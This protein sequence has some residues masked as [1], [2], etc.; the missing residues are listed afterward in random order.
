MASVNM[1][2]PPV[3][4][5]GIFQADVRIEGFLPVFDVHLGLV[6]L[7]PETETLLFG[8]V[9][10][11]ADHSLLWDLND[12]DVLDP[13]S[14]QK[15]LYFAHPSYLAPSG[16]DLVG[17]AVGLDLPPY[18]INRRRMEKGGTG[19]RVK[20]GSAGAGQD[21]SPAGQMK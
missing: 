4:D 1:D 19:K 6:A 10:K 2:V 20:N 17:R 11:V 14:L 8:D 7:V 21:S 12:N 18:L 16:V 15:N 9:E 13:F 5:T 3:A